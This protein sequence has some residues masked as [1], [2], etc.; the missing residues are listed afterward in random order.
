LALYAG[1]QLLW[2]R[3]KNLGNKGGMKRFIETLLGEI[4]GLAAIVVEGDRDLGTLWERAAARRKIDFERVSAET[5]RRQLL[6]S[7][8]QRTGK[9]AKLKADG[10][11]REIIKRSGISADKALRHDAAEAILIGYWAIRKTS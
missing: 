10:H 1:D 7:R 4:D 8:E 2:Y 6:L 5:W 3:S 9:Q 11:A